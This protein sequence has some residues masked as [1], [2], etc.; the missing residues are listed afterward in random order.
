MPFENT[1]G[2]YS[3]KFRSNVNIDN[4]SEHNQM[5]IVTEEIILPLGA[6]ASKDF[7]C[8]GTY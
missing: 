3:K 2:G 4:L 6:R 5:N 1:L 8:S 7:S